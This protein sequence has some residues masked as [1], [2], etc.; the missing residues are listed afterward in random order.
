MQKLL[1]SIN[2]GHLQDIAAGPRVATKDIETIAH[3]QANCSCQG[4][5]TFD[6]E[7]RTFMGFKNAPMRTWTGSGFVNVDKTSPLKSQ[8]AVSQILARS[9]KAVTRHDEG[10]RSPVGGPKVED[11]DGPKKKRKGLVHP[12]LAASMDAI[13]GRKR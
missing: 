3:H 13:L 5:K 1:D 11:E 8:P 6:Q 2:M 4:C 10:A 9:F 12:K 7:A